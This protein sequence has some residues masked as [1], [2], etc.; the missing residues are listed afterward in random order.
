[1]IAYIQGGKEVQLTPS[2]A[3]VIRA[4]MRLEK[5]D[6]GRLMLFGNGQLDIRMKNDDGSS[7]NKNSIYSTSIPCDGG[8]GGDNA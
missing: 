6:F 2:E 3:K 5:M 8:D 1:M 7:W 4:I